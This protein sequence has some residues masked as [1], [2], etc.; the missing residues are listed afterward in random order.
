MK[1]PGL[2]E[3]RHRIA[4]RERPAHQVNVVERLVEDG[5]GREPEP[6]NAAPTAL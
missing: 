3:G 5:R 2:T 6:P 4:D 1:R